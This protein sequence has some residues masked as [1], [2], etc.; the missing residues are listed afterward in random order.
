MREG[1]ER[2]FPWLYSTPISS[3]P[4]HFMRSSNPMWHRVAII[5]EHTKQFNLILPP[6]EQATGIT[7]INAGQ[8]LPGLSF[9]TCPVSSL[10]SISI[11]RSKRP[12]WKHGRVSAM[13]FTP[14]L[15]FV[16]L[17]SEQIGYKSRMLRLLASWRE[18][19]FREKPTEKN[20]IVRY[21]ISYNL[22]NSFRVQ[23]QPWILSFS[24]PEDLG[25]IVSHFCSRLCCFIL[26]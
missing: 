14:M 21:R 24:D 6:S 13:D 9:C 4:S 5:L 16:E 20:G 7:W 3:F 2:A 8:G 15:K 22:N 10:Q 12:W 1:Q 11:L 17:I 25:A 18:N 26:Y 23:I 19:C